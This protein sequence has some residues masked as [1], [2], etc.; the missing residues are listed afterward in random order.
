MPKCLLNDVCT[1]LFGNTLLET[2]RNTRNLAITCKKLRKKLKQTIHLLETQVANVQR[3]KLDGRMIIYTWLDYMI[4]DSPNNLHFVDQ[5]K[6]TFL[7][8]MDICLLPKLTMR[9][10]KHPSIE[11]LV[12]ERKK[13]LWHSK[14]FEYRFRNKK[15][16][17]KFDKVATLFFGLRHLKVIIWDVFEI[18]DISGLAKLQKL[19]SI[20]IV[21]FSKSRTSNKS[22]SIVGLNLFNKNITIVIS[23]V[24]DNMSN[25]AT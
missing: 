12:Y 22:L 15:L 9:L 5:N 10:K 14:F 7:N 11:R 13:L 20:K 6:R 2:F 18:V 4:Q 3:E 25:H 23:D 8:Q 1:N 17:I 21:N 24:R 19:Q 16:E